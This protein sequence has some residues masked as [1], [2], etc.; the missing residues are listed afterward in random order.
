M[1]DSGISV[2]R[3]VLA[4]V[5]AVAIL[6][7][8]VGLFAYDASV[9]RPGFAK[10]A[11]PADEIGSRALGT[12]RFTNVAATIV[13]A[14]YFTSTTAA[15]LNA[16]NAT[17]AVTLN[18]VAVT[19]TMSTA[20]FTATQSALVPTLNATGASTLDSATITKTLSTA[21]FT[22]TQSALVP[23]L[24][25]TG[26]STQDSVAI[27]KT[28][29]SAYI[30]ATNVISMAGATFTGPIKYGAEATYSAGAAITHGF[31][32]TPT[33]CGLIGS[34]ALITASVQGISSTTFSL[35]TE[36]NGATVYWMCG[37]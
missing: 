6:A 7:T 34:S 9:V 35:L 26:A 32:T 14:P 30:T 13:S 20:Y 17:G 31:A 3:Q 10:L 29:S 27:S 23:T 37:K 22:A 8:G 33:V 2:M 11:P 15:L 12:G 18:S 19:T 16:A 5:I 28:L 1:K 36:A 4:L 24:N 21:Y 25:V